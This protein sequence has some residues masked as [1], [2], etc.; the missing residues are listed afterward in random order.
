MLSQIILKL[1]YDYII[2]LT[3]KT[4]E[5]P[6]SL[7]LFW[8]YPKSY[9]S[10]TLDPSIVRVKESWVIPA[11]GFFEVFLIVSQLIRVGLYTDQEYLRCY[12][13]GYDFIPLAIETGG[14]QAKATEACLCRLIDITGCGV[15]LLIEHV[16]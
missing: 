1:K 13:M 4:S 7:Y 8:R 16:P 15:A 2:I 10:V 3:L 11:R 6:Y 12:Q 14:R 9:Q 5:Y